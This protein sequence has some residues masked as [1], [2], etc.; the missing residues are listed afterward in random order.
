MT[1]DARL[2]GRLP[3]AQE[4]ALYFVAAEALTNVAKHAHACAT[5]IRLRRDEGWAEI[6]VADDGV[7]GAAGAGGSG[8]RGLADRLD[9]LGGQIADH[10]RA[11]G[12]DHRARP[13]APG[14]SPAPRRPEPPRHSSA[15]ASGRARRVIA[16]VCVLRLPAASVAAITAVAASRERAARAVRAA[17]T[18]SGGT[19]ACCLDR[20]SVFRRPSCRPA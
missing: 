1:V 2:D 5:A 18:A 9:A 3:P 20:V 14:L 8:L 15:S 12:R 17:W 16:R 10:E 19:S 4:A 13:R 11:G 7:G 6:T